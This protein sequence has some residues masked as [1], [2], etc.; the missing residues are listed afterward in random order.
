[1]RGAARRAPGD[2]LIAEALRENMLGEDLRLSIAL[3]AR[4][5]IIRRPS[6]SLSA[7]RRRRQKSFGASSIGWLDN[8]LAASYSQTRAQTLAKAKYSNSNPKYSNS[9]QRRF[10]SR[11]TVM[12][13]D[14]VQ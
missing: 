12:P 6:Q 8:R 11:M 2:G 5:R 10:A 14:Q 9:N 7:I 4:P 3:A 1:M 13:S